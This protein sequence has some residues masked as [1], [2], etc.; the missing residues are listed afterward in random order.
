MNPFHLLPYDIIDMVLF[1]YL[2]ENNCYAFISSYQ[3]LWNRRNRLYRPIY[4]REISTVV[5]PPEDLY[6]AVTKRVLNTYVHPKRFNRHSLDHFARSGYEIAFLRCLGRSLRL[7]SVVSS[8][9]KGGHLH[10]ID[11]FFKAQNH[12]MVQSYHDS[13]VLSAIELGQ[14][15]VINNM[16][17]R[18][19]EITEENITEAVR[20]KQHAILEYFLDIYKGRIDVKGHM[21]VAVDNDDLET[22]KI[23]SSFD[24]LGQVM[25]QD[26]DWFLG[27][28]ITSQRRNCLEFLESKVKVFSNALNA[29]IKIGDFDLFR[30]YL[31]LRGPP[32]I[33]TLDQCLLWSIETQHN[34][35]AEYLL[36]EGAECVDE[37]LIV[38][39]KFNKLINVKLLIRYGAKVNKHCYVVALNR[40]AHNI[41]EYLMPLLSERQQ[42]HMKLRCRKGPLI[43]HDRHF[44]N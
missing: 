39:V 25:S 19:H 23:L 6:Y 27:I 8:M 24:K 17:E 7:T 40:R 33:K 42:R 35:I 41:C 43:Y 10:I 15:H 26:Y 11:A 36:N 12:G 30:R 4:L 1:D 20:L 3:A 2:K 28:H 14:I 5:L 22:L 18:G 38:A 34:L 44:K 29:A 31:Y 16:I 37:A 32:S 9:V 13:I 21:Y